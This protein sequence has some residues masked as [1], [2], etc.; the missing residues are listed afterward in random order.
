MTA[1]LMI[2]I[3]AV[4]GL[5]AGL[6]VLWLAEVLAARGRKMAAVNRIREL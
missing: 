2:V 6:A 5:I 4:V 3:P 1:I